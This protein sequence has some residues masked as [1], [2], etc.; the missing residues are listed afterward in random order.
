LHS[1]SFCPYSGK[2]L[3]FL[4]L[5]LEEWVMSELGDLLDHLVRSSR[6]SR[7]E[8]ARVVEEV[9]AFFNENPEAFVCRRHRA[10]QGAGL[11]N[12]AIFARIADELS[13]FR[14]RA[15]TYTERQLR[16]IIYG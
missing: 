7:S 12:S 5:D 4:V 11:S 6:L 2:N 9:F 16:R 8:A 15:P 3:A 1:S 14:F 13:C 10:L